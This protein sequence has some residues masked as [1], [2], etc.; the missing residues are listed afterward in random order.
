MIDPSNI[1]DYNR[2]DSEL[3]RFALFSIAVAGKTAFIIAKQ[4]EAFL[5]LG[6]GNT[7]FQRVRDLI[8]RGKLNWALRKARLG[9]YSILNKAF[10]QIVNVD[11]RNCTV[12]MLENVHG[13]GPKTARFFLLH[14]RKDLRIAALDTHMLHYL[15]D[16]GYDAPTSTPSSKKKYAELEQAFISEADKHNMSV[17]DFDL[18]IWNKFGRVIKNGS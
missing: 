15:R 2:S 1:T 17:A 10:R 3:E 14:S 13:V 12:D 7:P 4:L 6:N 5:S 11:V 8:S 9:K 18:M 16:Q